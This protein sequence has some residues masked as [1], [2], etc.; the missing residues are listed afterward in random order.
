MNTPFDS[1][2]A[3]A[4]GM[5]SAASNVLPHL[6]PTAQPDITLYSPGMSIDEGYDGLCAF[7]KPVNDFTLFEAHPGQ[8]GMTSTADFFPAL[9]NPELNQFGGQFDNSLFA[10]P[11][12]NPYDEMMAFSNPL[13]QN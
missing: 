12:H 4:L 2:E 9:N 1:F 10:E 8:M 6:S 11:M 13:N 5:D 7:D 3:M